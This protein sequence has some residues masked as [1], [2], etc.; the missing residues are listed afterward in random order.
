MTSWRLCFNRKTEAAPLDSYEMADHI[1]VLDM[2][3]QRCNSV[4]RLGLCGF[5]AR[6]AMS[7][8][9]GMDRKRSGG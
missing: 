7:P 4:W 3:T 2:I 5:V 9:R 8:W 6:C 1:G